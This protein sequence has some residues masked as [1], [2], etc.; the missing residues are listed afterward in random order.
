MPERSI[1]WLALEP[2]TP[3]EASDGADLGTVQQVVADRQKD[4]FSGVTIRG[5]ILDRER[6]VPADAIQ[7]LTTERVK[8]SLSATEAETLEDY[9]R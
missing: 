7:E 9:D 4:I 2:G 8:L 6:F 3:V 5:H 1:A